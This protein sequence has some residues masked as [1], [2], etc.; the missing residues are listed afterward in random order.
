MSLTQFRLV[1]AAATLVFATPAVAG[2]EIY[3]WRDPAGN[4]VLSDRP[5]EGGERTY[6]VGTVGDIRTTQPTKRSTAYDPI[7]TE[8]ATA[9]GIRPDLVRAVIH[10]ES[11]FNPT[12]LS[13]K[14]AMGLMQLMPA[15]ALAYGVTNAYDPVQTSAPAWPICGACCSATRTTRSSRWRRTTPARRQSRNTTACRR[16]ARLATTSRRSATKPA[17]ARPPRASTKS[18]RSRTATK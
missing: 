11:A 4:L 2:A 9:Q 12:A 18:S 10:A 5:K 7:I 1:L 8:H 15:T 14:G 17:P 13:I 3:T 16:T 6:A